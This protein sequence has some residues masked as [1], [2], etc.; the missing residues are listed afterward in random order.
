VSAQRHVTAAEAEVDQVGDR[1][2][3]NTIVNPIAGTVLATYAEA[4]EFVQQGQPL[5][6][7]A[8]LEWVEVR[9]YVAETQLAH[10]RVGQTAHV[11][12]DTGRDARRTVP[13][14]VSWIASEAEFTPTPIQTREERADL[15]YAVKIRVANDGGLLK[16]GMP[17]DVRFESTESAPPK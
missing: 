8:N 16:I 7:I 2:R 15:V 6:K 11:T 3:K 4:G 10:V 12:V 9:A 14:S 5:Y 1:I 17:A 13:G